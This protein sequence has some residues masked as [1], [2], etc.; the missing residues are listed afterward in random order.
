MMALGALCNAVALE[1]V[2]TITK[3]DT[4]KE[5]RD[6]ISTMRVGDDHVTKVTMQ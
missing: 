4:T 3:K 1:M 6:V 2:S 5:F